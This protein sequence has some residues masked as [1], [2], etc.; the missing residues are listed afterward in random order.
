MVLLNR[1]KKHITPLS[2]HPTSSLPV[3]TCSRMEVSSQDSGKPQIPSSP[4]KRTHKIPRS[5]S[6]SLCYKQ[7]LNRCQK[8][9]QQ[10]SVVSV[11]LV[12]ERTWRKK[13][14][15]GF[16]DHRGFAE[17]IQKKTRKSP[18]RGQT[19]KVPFSSQLTEDQNKENR[20]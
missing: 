13:N 20:L 9:W 5:P 14:Y 8:S 10:L 6:F 16:S 17:Q 18:G 15:L 7:Q 12:E 19:L 11:W 3:Q 4:P 2:C 1:L